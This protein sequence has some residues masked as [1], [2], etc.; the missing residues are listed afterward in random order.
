VEVNLPFPSRPGRQSGKK[1]EAPRQKPEPGHSRPPA[2]ARWWLIPNRVLQNSSA[3]ADREIREVGASTG[4]KF[5]S[6]RSF[7]DTNI[8]IEADDRSALQDNVEP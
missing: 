7:F 2:A 4:T 3:F 5:M 6:A 1:A 8:L